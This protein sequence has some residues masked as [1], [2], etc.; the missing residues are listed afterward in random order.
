MVT[1]PPCAPKVAG[2]LVELP[3][4]TLPNDSEVGDIVNCAIPVPVKPIVSGVLAA[5]LTTDIVPETELPEDGVNCAVQVTLCPTD[6]V[7]GSV[8]P[9]TLNADPETLIC[10]IVALAAPVF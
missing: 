1:F 6:N 3:S 8:T 10:E 5:L 4:S 9:V 2:R 7:I